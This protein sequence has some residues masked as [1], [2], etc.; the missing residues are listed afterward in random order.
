MFL[1]EYRGVG[2]F[3]RQVVVKQIH[4]QHAANERFV[5]MFVDEANIAARLTHPNVIQVLDLQQEGADLYMVLEHVDGLDLNTLF[6]HLASQGKKLPAEVALYLVTQVLAGLIHAHAATAPDG[7][8]LNLIHRDITPGNVLLGRQG[9]VKLSD[10]GVARAANRMTQTVVGEVKGKY[11]YMAPEV[12]QGDPYDQRSD[13]FG[14][15]VVLWEALTTRPLFRGKSDFHVM[16]QVLRGQLYPPSAYNQ[17]SPK[18]LDALVMKALSRQVEQRFSSARDM[19]RALSDYLMKSDQDAALETLVELVNTY[20]PANLTTPDLTAPPP[21]PLS[22]PSET[23]APKPQAASPDAAAAAP[24]SER[25]PAVPL[26]PAQPP[27]HTPAHTPAP[28]AAATTPPPRPVSSAPLTPLPGPPPGAPA[29]PRVLSAMP[30]AA[31][32]NA[33]ADNWAPDSLPPGDADTAW[34]QPPTG[35]EPGF[36]ATLGPTRKAVGPLSTA[37]IIHLLQNRDASSLDRVGMSPGALIPLPDLGRLLM[38]DHL[39]RLPTPHGPPTLA[40]PLKE[41]GAPRLL[42]MVGSQRLSGALQLH[43]AAGVMMA[44]LHEGM[45]QYTFLPDPTHHLLSLFVQH[46][47]NGRALLPQILQGVLRDRIS[48]PRVMA[49]LAG[50]SGGR[51]NAAVGALAR[52]RLLHGLSWEGATFAFHAGL[53]APYDLSPGKD[54]VLG[55]LPAS[56]TRTFKPHEVTAQ[57]SNL[58][59]QPLDLDAGDEKLLAELGVAREAEALRSAMSGQA[60]L[61][62]SWPK[63]VQPGSPDEQRLLMALVVLKECGLLTEKVRA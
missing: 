53:N 39:V 63:L 50:L 15:G 42:M 17:E 26:S 24:E 56:I 2:G 23:T 38:L 60:T 55:V 34:I 40:G 28:A 14:V 5:K 25:S 59:D 21:A 1:A 35:G 19:K 10:F 49:K 27:V 32:N 8:P 62:A 61:R 16:E 46:Q 29:P 52:E 6:N 13:V 12:M 45:L 48:L 57:A 31:A 4:E 22:G 11:S 20:A 18:D 9:Q 54:S 33:G 41:H 44:F 3:S 36:H 30:A 43:G 37:S 51:I 58:L 47:A 7:T